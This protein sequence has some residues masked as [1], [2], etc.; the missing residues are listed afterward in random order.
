MMS[1]FLKRELRHF[2]ANEF[3][4]GVRLSEITR[5]LDGVARIQAEYA[6]CAGCPIG[7][8]PSYDLRKYCC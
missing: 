2:V 8:D 5:L 7:V 4:Y 3:R 1:V 6:L